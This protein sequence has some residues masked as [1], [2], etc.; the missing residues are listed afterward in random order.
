MAPP[1]VGRR[2]EWARL[3]NAGP[4]LLLVAGEPGVGKTRLARDALPGATVWRCRDGLQTIPLLPAAEWLKSVAAQV[5]RAVGD[6][7]ALREL[8]RLEPSLAPGERL[9]PPEGDSARLLL[10]LSAVVPR[11]TDTLLVD[12]LQWVDAAT[13]PRCAC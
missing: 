13:L 10:A 4:G 9:P 12:D 2:D 6:A 7:T 11:L 1:L 3:R 5:P 8:A